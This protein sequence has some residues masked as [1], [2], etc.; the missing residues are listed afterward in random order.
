MHSSTFSSNAGSGSFGTVR[1][2]VLLLA[3]LIALFVVAELGTRLVIGHLS[4][5]LSRIRLE[6]SAAK[7]IGGA[8]G[9]TRQLL[10]VGNSLLIAG[11][12]VD[13]LNEPLQPKWR[14]VRFGIEQTTYYDWYF[15]L[16]RLAAEGSRP[17][18]IVVCF[19]P[20]HLI[21]SSVRTEMFA[22]YLMRMRDTFEVSQ[23][24]ELNP[25]ATADLLLANVSEFW[26]LRKE[27]RKN[28]LGRLMPELPRLAKLIAHGGGSPPPQGEALV[29]T[30]RSRLQALR[31]T[32]DAAGAKLIVV[33][34]PPMDS[35]QVPALQ[36]LGTNIGVPILMPLTDQDLQPDD[37]EPDQY[38]LS[39]V[40]RLRFTRAL[41]N[42]LMKIL[43]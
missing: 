1:A 21:G 37:Y 39:E 38:H 12:D 28:V 30:A 13:A 11:V 18:A 43:Q 7:Q 3:G 42:D 4:H 19:E 32:A 33:L 14:G 8:A 6:S 10:M 25:T 22:H 15:G 29:S 16:K 23:V 17:N 5:S 31:A 40:G 20:R 27:I 35:A 9:D 24:L 36:V 34:M 26:A 2:T 41:T